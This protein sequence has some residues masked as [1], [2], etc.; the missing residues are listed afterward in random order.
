[1]L[2]SK[3]PLEIKFVDDILKHLRK[4][5]QFSDNIKDIERIFVKEPNIQLTMS[6]FGG[7]SPD[8]NYNIVDSKSKFLNSVLSYLNK[9]GFVSY[10]NSIV[11]ITFEGIVKIS[12]G[13]FS[14]DYIDT[15]YN[16]FFKRILWVISMLAFLLSLVNSCHALNQTYT[17]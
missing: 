1:M 15:K 3:A 13:G 11:G 2:N 5:N 6:I 8:T 4:S 14:Q 12:N 17:C 7:K 16:R 10:E 9:N